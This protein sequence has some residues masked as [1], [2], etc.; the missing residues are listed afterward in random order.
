[1]KKKPK[2]LRR[3]RRLVI[4]PLRPADFARWH[5]AQSAR[6]PA[7]NRYERPAPKAESLTRAVFRKML[8]FQRRTRAADLVFH[9]GVF[10][11]SG[12]ALIGSVDLLVMTRLSIQAANLGY[13]IHNSHW[14]RGFAQEAS[15]AALDIAFRELGLH[16]V[17]A[18]MDPGNRASSGVARGIG[19]RREGL[20]K[21]F[22]YDGPKAGWIDLLVYGTTAEDWGIRRMKPSVRARMTELI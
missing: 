14:G 10:L 20:R 9:F 17:E 22:L 6:G 11:R 21:N 1:M 13:A 2:L 19:M 4:R 15:R 5:R 8:S 7:K 3:T 18:S 16:R 12:G